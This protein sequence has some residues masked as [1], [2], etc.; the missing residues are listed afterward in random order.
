MNEETA[1]SDALYTADGLRLQRVSWPARVPPWGAGRGTVLIVHGLGEHAQ[2]YVRLA[3]DLCAAGWQVQSWDQRGHGDSDGAR[4]A[5][6]ASTSLL[7]DLALMLRTLRDD[8]VPRPLVLLGHS[9][10]GAV[11][12]RHV[13]DRLSVGSDVDALV[14][15][16]PALD[17]GLSRRQRLQLW[18]GMR[19]APDRAVDNGIESSWISRDALVARQYDDDTRVHH[20]VTPRLA[21]CIVDCGRA[22]LAAAPHWRLPT[23]LMWSGAD[24]CVAPQGSAAFAAAAPRAVVTTRCFDGLAH[25][26]FNEP[27]REFVVG[28]LLEW[29]ET[30]P[31]SRRRWQRQLRRTGVTSIAPSAGSRPRSLAP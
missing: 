4:G 29:L 23:L 1:D 6:A 13:A 30:M 31:A 15:S 10:G 18:L 11:A 22:A 2:R 9:M 24:R 19:L 16:S 5:V 21:Q 17:A 26:I 14:L 12:A 28:A 20:R 8:E 27:E 25:E 7:D 3:A